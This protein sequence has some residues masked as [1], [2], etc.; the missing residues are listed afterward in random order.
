MKY[1]SIAAPL[2]AGLLLVDAQDVPRPKIRIT[3]VQPQ[4]WKIPEAV[5][6]PGDEVTIDAASDLIIKSRN[7]Q[8]RVHRTLHVEP[9]FSIAYERSVNGIRYSWSVE[10]GRG[11]TQSIQVFATNAFNGPL[12]TTSAQPYWRVQRKSA[13]PSVT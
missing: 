8:L 9:Q 7:T 12:G 6:E 13:D 3:S 1:F 5:P 2:F 10:N 4:P 11:A